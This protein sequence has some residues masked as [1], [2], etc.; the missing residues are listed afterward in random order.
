MFR[1]DIA[2]AV[3]ASAAVGTDAPRVVH[4]GES[5]VLAVLMAI[6][7]LFILFGWWL[8]MKQLLCGR[9]PLVKPVKVRVRGYPFALAVQ[10]VFG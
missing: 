5:A 10:R 9:A 3:F 7:T 2:G 4:L 8:V 6:T 1:S